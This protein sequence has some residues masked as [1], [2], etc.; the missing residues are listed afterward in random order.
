MVLFNYAVIGYHYGYWYGKMV[1]LQDGP[2][3][4]FVHISTVERAGLS[5][6]KLRVEGL[7]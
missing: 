1:Q 7:F 6:F 4:A 3:D 2:S 5:S